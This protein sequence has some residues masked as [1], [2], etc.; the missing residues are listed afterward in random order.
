MSAEGI[1]S[2]IERPSCPLCRTNSKVR[3]S[4]YEPWNVRE[5]GRTGRTYWICS[6][7]WN[8]DVT[9]EE[10]ER[11]VFGQET[12]SVI[13]AE[14]QAAQEERAQQYILAPKLQRGRPITPTET[15][16]F[17]RIGFAVDKCLPR[18]ETLIARR[19]SLPERIKRNR[20]QVRTE[21]LSAGFCEQEIDAGLAAKTA[22]I[23]ARHFIA[24][25]EDM[26]FDL[27]AEYHR[28]YR[29]ILKNLSL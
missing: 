17:F 3:F 21:L 7:G 18:F 4:H 29:S 16:R 14:R 26:S 12:A 24:H 6:C 11:E 13:A 28:E 27:V 22:K 25:T 5:P 10:A 19:K 20:R 9:L 23:A 8:R 1:P 15:K 2:T